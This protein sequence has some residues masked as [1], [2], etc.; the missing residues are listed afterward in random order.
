MMNMGGSTNHRAM[1][2]ARDIKP[3]LSAQKMKAVYSSKH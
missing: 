2:L 1:I 3:Y